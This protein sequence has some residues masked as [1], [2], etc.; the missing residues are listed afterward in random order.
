M[1]PC[2][3]CN[4]SR[5]KQRVWSSLSL[6]WLQICVREPFDSLAFGSLVRSWWMELFCKFVHCSDR[7]VSVWRHS[8][9]VY[10]QTSIRRPC[11]LTVATQRRR[12]RFRDYRPSEESLP[13]GRWPSGGRFMKFPLDST[14]SEIPNWCGSFSSSDWLP[15][16][17]VPTIGL[18]RPSL[19][20]FPPTLDT[21]GHRSTWIDS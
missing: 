5:G 12:P 8:M 1:S 2:G 3:L 17:Q 4:V 21:V 18:L 20:G 13:L 14:W 15:R 7:K 9:E 6:C 11:S 16:L 19:G 10:G